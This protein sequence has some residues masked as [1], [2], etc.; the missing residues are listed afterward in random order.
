MEKDSVVEQLAEAFVLA[1]DRIGKKDVQAH[2]TGPGSLFG[3]GG[4]FSVSGLERDI[5]TAQVR[6]FGLLEKLPRFA[7]VL[8]QPRFGTITGI[9]DDVGNEPAYP[10]DNAPSGYLKGCNL[11][12]AFGRV[13]RATNTIEFDKVMRQLHGGINTDLQLRGRMLGLEGLTP[14]GLSEADIV[15]IYTMSEMVSAGVRLERKLNVMTW[16]G[17]PANN[18]A[19][20]G[21][22]EFPGLDNQIATGQV[23]ADTNVAC[24]A[25]DSDVKDF[26]YGSV[27]GVTPS[28]VEYLSMLEFY[29]RF[30]AE[31]MG[32]T[33][34]TWIIAMRPELW[35]ELSSCWPCQY[36]TNKCATSVVGTSTVVID[37]RENVA[38]RDAM[39]NGKYIDINGNRYAVITD[40]G[41]FEHTNI[42]NANVPAGSYASSIYMVPLLITGN[43]P[44]TYMEHVDYTAGL[45]DVALLNGKEEFWTDR[46]LFSWAIKN[47]AWCYELMVKIEPRVVLRTPQLAGRIDHV[48]YSPLQHLRSPDPDSP[49]NY[50]GGVSLRG[51]PTSY[52]TWGTRE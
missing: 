29:L 16:Q 49:Y 22:A 36:N 34:A 2:V 1:A 43:F 47:L 33:P 39:R 19:G 45:R 27:C 50:D 21:Y 13:A 32:L 9:T 52:A 17:S 18:N 51:R 38:E 26:A 6:P 3:A 44:V 35:F 46:G 11:T 41:I 37:G 10:C 48:L 20:G 4:V 42:N 31:T 24:P 23:D 14:A 28:I 15:N 30:N 7:S 8:E 5:I 12:A 40:T 25:L